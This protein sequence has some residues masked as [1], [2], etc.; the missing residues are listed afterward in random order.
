[1][2]TIIMVKKTARAPRRPKRSASRGITRQP[3]IVAKETSMTPYDANWAARGPTRPAASA[4]EVMAAGTYTVP[5]HRPEIDASINKAFTIVRRRKAEEN[6]IA[7]GRQTAHDRTIFAFFFHV[8]G[9]TTPCRTQ[10]QQEC[11]KAS[12][13]TWHASRSGCRWRSWPA[14]LENPT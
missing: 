11:R 3:R 4:S 12:N 7:N 6:R 5:A 8:D 9:S 13:T 2:N 10:S 1:M 14:R